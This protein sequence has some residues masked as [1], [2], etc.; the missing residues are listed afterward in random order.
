MSFTRKVGQKIQR[1]G[2]MVC[3]ILAFTHDQVSVKASD[4]RLYIL[5]SHV[6]YK[7]SNVP[8]FF[9][10]GESYRFASPGGGTYKIDELRMLDNPTSPIEGLVAVAIASAT[11]GKEWLS[12][13]NK[14]DFNSMVKV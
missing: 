10:L 1:P 4:G 3:E 8:D 9:E 11:D 13:L 7:Y 5:A 6:D 12:L 2:G 14:Y